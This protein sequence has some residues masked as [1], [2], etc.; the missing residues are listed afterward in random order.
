[1]IPQ[2]REA[3][4]KEIARFQNFQT[5]LKYYGVALLKT[6]WTVEELVDASLEARICDRSA[7]AKRIYQLYRLSYFASA[8]LFSD[9]TP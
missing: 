1:V 9:A 5:F 6:R 2:T 7:R 4:I 8:A 3:L